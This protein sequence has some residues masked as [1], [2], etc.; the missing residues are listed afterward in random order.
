MSISSLIRGN[1]ATEERFFN[2]DGSALLQKAV[3]SE[4]QGLLS[5][6][7]FLGYALVTSATPEQR[8]SLCSAVM[9]RVAD[10]VGHQDLNIRDFSLRL[11]VALGRTEEGLASLR[12]YRESVVGALREHSDSIAVND[13]ADQFESEHDSVEALRALLSQLE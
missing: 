5:R 6:A 11:L 7:V 8:T 1:A 12:R 10:L 9:P 4:D 13:K 2:R 3:S